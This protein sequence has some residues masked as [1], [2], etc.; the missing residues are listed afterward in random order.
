MRRRRSAASVRFLRESES[1]V[2]NVESEVLRLM[3]KGRVELKLGVG[4]AE[5][6]FF[7]GMALGAGDGDFGESMITT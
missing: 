5:E 1:L 7:D 4:R 6:K 2:R 3:G